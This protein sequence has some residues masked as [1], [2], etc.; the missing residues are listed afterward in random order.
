LSKN[1]N[2]QTN[3]LIEVHLTVNDTILYHLI[4]ENEHNQKSFINVKVQNET[5]MTLE[6]SEG[7]KKVIRQVSGQKKEQRPKK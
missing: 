3:T 2:Q 6:G 4:Y 1:I 5:Y 7:Q